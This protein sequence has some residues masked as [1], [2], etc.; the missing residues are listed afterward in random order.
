[1][2]GLAHTGSSCNISGVRS[3]RGSSLGRWQAWADGDG[4]SHLVL[5]PL[6]SALVAG[7]L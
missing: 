2:Q 5:L 4:K 1:M 3:A 6:F 7:Q